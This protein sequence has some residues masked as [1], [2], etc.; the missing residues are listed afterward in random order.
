MLEHLDTALLD[1]SLDKELAPTA[2]DVEHS[3]NQRPSL[4]LREPEGFVVRQD[5]LQARGSAKPT[6]LQS[7][8]PPLDRD[9]GDRQDVVGGRTPPATSR[10]QQRVVARMVV[11]VGDHGVEHHAQE[12][13]AT[14]VVTLDGQ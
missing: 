2:D 13:F 10:L 12:Q 4:F 11:V 14:V 7:Q 8:V 6:N 3:I 5:V 9:H 1:T